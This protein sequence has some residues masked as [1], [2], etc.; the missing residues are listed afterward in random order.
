LSQYWTI[1][2]E[3]DRIWSGDAGTFVRP[4][5]P[6][7]LTYLAAGG[8]PAPITEQALRA[9]VGVDWP[10]FLIRLKTEARSVLAGQPWMPSWRQFKERYD[11]DEAFAAAVDAIRPVY[12]RPRSVDNPDWKQFLRR[13]ADGER[14]PTLY[15]VDGMP[16]RSQYK[17]RWKRDKRFAAEVTAANPDK[18]GAPQ[19]GGS[20]SKDWRHFLDRIASGEALRD[21]LGDT[22]MPTVRMYYDQLKHPEFREQVRDAKIAGGHQRHPV[23]ITGEIMAKAL[24]LRKTGLSMDAI[25]SIKGMPTG[26]SMNRWLAERP[27]LRGQFQAFNR[28][29]EP[30]PLLPAVRKALLKAI[31]H[32]GAQMHRVV[33]QQRMHRYRK[34]DPDLDREIRAILKRREEARISGAKDNSTSAIAAAVPATLPPIVRDEVAAAMALAVQDGTLRPE[35]IHRRAK[36]FVAAYFR[37]YSEYGPASLDQKMFEDGPATLGDKID[38]NSFHF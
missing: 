3:P 8:T 26:L 24:D 14:M 15:G 30:L 35:Q 13:L 28:K 9:A 33:S 38:G 32:H 6:D 17:A 11:R 12:P 27:A 10:S 25:G 2:E 37:T 1:I 4:D 18:R 19:A 22:G 31:E 34:E 36:E 16:T 23:P 21:V 7:Y 5:D 29:N 20:Q